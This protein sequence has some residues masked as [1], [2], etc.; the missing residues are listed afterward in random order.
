MTSTDSTTTDGGVAPSE[1]ESRVVKKVA[2]RLIP[3]LILLYF[4]NY[5]DRTNIAFAKLTMSADLGM[6]ET[7][8]GLA[9][10]LF[11]VGYLL[12]EVPSNL[13]LHRFGARLW[14]ARIM[15]TWGILA[16]ALAFVPNVG[17]LYFLRILL[18][19]AE[20]GFFP[21]VLLYLTFWFP[22]KYRVRLMG[23]FLL[24]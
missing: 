2:R 22:K 17:S 6:T 4:V 14:I 21:G 13:A 5:L 18:G 3:F 11:F 8:F 10:G 1:I 19:I 9:S 12:F 16:A 15:L 20:A 23:L 24:T 7:M